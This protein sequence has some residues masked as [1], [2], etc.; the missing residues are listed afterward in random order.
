MALDSYSGLKAEIAD[1]TGKQDTTARVDTFIDL[2]ESWLN[3]SLRTYEMETTNGSLTVSSGLITHPTDFLGWK[4][5]TT[6][7]NGLRYQLQPISLEQRTFYDDG[8]AGRPLKYVVRGGSTVL[9]PTPDSSYIVE[10]TYYQK[11]PALGAS[12]TQNWVLTS[13]PELYLF[14][15]LMAAEAFYKDDPRIQGW[16]QLAGEKLAETI[17]AYRNANF[18]QVPTMVVDA[19]VY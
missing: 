8:V 7:S 1:W 9:V 4:N 18:G 13:H 2:A 5:I 14:G 16:S 15:A 12:V 11:I 19:P 17:Q 3:K 6:T 10:G